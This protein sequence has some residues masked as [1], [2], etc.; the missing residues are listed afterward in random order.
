MTGRIFIT[1]D[2]HGT[3]SP[4]FGLAEHNALYPE[5]ILLIAGDAGYVWDERTATHVGTLEQLFP[6]TVAF[7]D[8]NHENHALLNA[9]PVESWFGGRVHRVGERVV[10]LM[11]GELYAIY[12]QNLFAFGGARSVDVDR[13]EDGFSWWK[14]EGAS[15]WPEE[16]PSAEEISYGQRQLE[17]HR[18]EI[19]YVITHE[20]PLLARAS[21]TRSKII[22]PDYQ[23]PALFD[24]WYELLEDAPQFRKWYCGHMHVDQLI[25]PRLRVVY[26]NILPLGEENRMRWA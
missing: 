7:V 3:F 8:G 5:D 14:Q 21:I 9:M 26:N 18:G 25:T 22:D 20:T 1:G 19:H 6:G 11:R 16:E 12:G 23:L 13:R 10:H 4:L 17:A 15:W 2:K 24:R